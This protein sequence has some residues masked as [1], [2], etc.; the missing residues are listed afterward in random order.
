MKKAYLRMVVS[1]LLV[2]FVTA[3]HGCDSSNNDFMQSEEK[4]ICECPIKEIGGFD[5]VNDLTKVKLSYNEGG[6]LKIE[7]TC[8]GGT[9]EKVLDREAKVSDFEKTLRDN[10]IYYDKGN[11]RFF[12]FDSL[13]NKYREVK[14]NWFCSNQ[15]PRDRLFF[16]KDHNFYMAIDN[17][18]EE[19]APL[20]TQYH[21]SP[22]RVFSLLQNLKTEWVGFCAFGLERSELFKEVL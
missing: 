11:F 19:W 12:S 9:F 2:T 15:V 5:G 13:G 3:G 16:N 8:L 4:V 14:F 6:Y 1:A 17:K 20:R 21:S 7:Y 18:G 10:V 22:G